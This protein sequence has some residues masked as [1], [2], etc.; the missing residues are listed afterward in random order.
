MISS[1]LPDPVFKNKKI[2]FPSHAV[3]HKNYTE[4]ISLTEQFEHLQSYFT[5]IWYDVWWK[6]SR[7]NLAK[8][9]GMPKIQLLI[10][11]NYGRKQLLHLYTANTIIEA[12]PEW[13]SAFYRLCPDKPYSG[14]RRTP[15]PHTNT[16][17]ESAWPESWRTRSLAKSR[18]AWMTAIAPITSHTKTWS[19][20]RVQSAPTSAAVV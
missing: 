20:R 13:V 10:K 19:Y 7:P 15:P 1:G 16:I 18:R 8:V 12:C 6:V 9:S 4:N 2:P 3:H 14:V 5:L 11:Q 17:V